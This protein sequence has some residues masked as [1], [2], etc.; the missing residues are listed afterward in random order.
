M[1]YVLGVFLVNIP[2][3]N[4][5]VQCRTVDPLQIVDTRRLKYTHFD[6]ENH[7]P[8]PVNA[9]VDLK[10][11]GRYIVDIAPINLIKQLSFK[12]TMQQGVLLLSNMDI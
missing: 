8:T 10:K 11:S 12:Q 1:A 3:G 4:T 6:L 5:P 7:L 9:R 2:K